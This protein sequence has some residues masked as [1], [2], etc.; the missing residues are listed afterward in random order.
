MRGPPSSIGSEAG[1]A[2]GAVAQRIRGGMMPVF[3]AQDVRLSGR[4]GSHRRVAQY[5]LHR[6]IRPLLRGEATALDLLRHAVLRQ[7]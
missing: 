7:T 4:Q 2:C 3:L 1:V 6:L 5:L